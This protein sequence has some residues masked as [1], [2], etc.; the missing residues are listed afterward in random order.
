MKER[1][2]YKDPLSQE[3]KETLTKDWSV[4]CFFNRNIDDDKTTQTVVSLI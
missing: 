1:Q 2:K 3:V 4:F